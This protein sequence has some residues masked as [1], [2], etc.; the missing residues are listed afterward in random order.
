M[1]KKPYI[2]ND[3]QPISG[4]TFLSYQQETLDPKLLKQL[5]RGDYPI[6]QVLDLHGLTVD[7]AMMVLED[8]LFEAQEMGYRCL[9]IIHG[10]GRGV[11]QGSAVMKNFVNDYLRSKENILAFCSASG[12]KGGTG[13]LYVLLKRKR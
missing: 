4:D 1:V 3:T 5:K 10:K 6:D 2:T 12:R 7:A 9:L 8:A 11:G 13:A